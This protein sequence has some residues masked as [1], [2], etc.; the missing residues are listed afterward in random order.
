MTR[1]ASVAPVIAVFDGH[2][3]ALTKDDHAQLAAGRSSG[4]LDLPRMRA[5]GVRG[6]IFAVFVASED[7]DWTPITR[8]DGVV[9]IPPAAPVPY[10]AAA[11]RAARAAGEAARARAQWG[12]APGA[13]DR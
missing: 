4:H 10:A 1:T 3:D 8:P 11:A 9:E 2:N 7:Q 13:D 5:G 12:G 6:A